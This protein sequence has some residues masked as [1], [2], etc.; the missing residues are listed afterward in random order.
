MGG[1]QGGCAAVDGAYGR[2]CGM[3]ENGGPASGGRAITAIENPRPSLPRPLTSP[4]HFRLR[5]SISCPV[6]APA[7]PPKYV[8]Q[9]AAPRSMSETADTGVW[10]VEEPLHYRARVSSR[11][12]DASDFALRV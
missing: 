11:L 4:C 6:R 2:A 8:F 9:T 7:G 3:P 10:S 1:L 12:S 5:F